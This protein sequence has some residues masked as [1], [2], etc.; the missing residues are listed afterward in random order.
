MSDAFE[1]LRPAALWIAASGIVV[2][3]LGVRAVRC[4]RAAVAQLLPRGRN[5]DPTLWSPW[6]SR[7]RWLF[8]VAALLLGAFALSGPTL[9]FGERPQVRRGIDLVLCLDTSR[10]MLARDVKPTRFERA[11][12][13]IGQLLGELGE[14]R[15]SLVAFAGDARQIA[16]LSRDRIALRQLLDAVELEDARLGGTDLGR[17]IEFALELFEERSGKHEAIVLVTDGE[18]L[19][20]AGLELAERAAERGIRIFVVGVGTTRGSKIP[21]ADALGDE[22]FLTGPDGEEVVTRL[23]DD[24][25]ERLA[26]ATGGAYSSTERSGRPLVDLFRGPI[27]D[28]ERRELESGTARVPD[29]RYQ[30]PLLLALLLVT[31]E[32]ALGERR[33][34]RDD[35][36]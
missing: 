35:E 33:S 18:D 6:R 36:R 7:M 32:S 9:G 4:R 17:A 8:A 14:N 10:S 5:G 21:I 29:D 11:K 3:G 20:E 16:P 22:R 19:S 30:W 27:Q 1:I 12:R 23:V 26:L 13:E 2:A 24:S 31:I 25:L 15:A 28:V 34:R